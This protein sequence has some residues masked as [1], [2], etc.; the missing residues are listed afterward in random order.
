MPKT[1]FLELPAV[2]KDKIL[3]NV[4]QAF[5]NKGLLGSS[6]DDIAQSINVS[7]EAFALYFEGL[8]DVIAT[9][10][11]RGIQY[12]S[13]AY[14]E[15]GRKQ[16][17]FW[18][19]VE[20]L[21]TLAAKRGIAFSPF[22]LVY[23]NVAAQNTPELAQATFDR[24]EGR[25]ALFFQNLILAGLQEGALRAELDV[26]SVAYH[27]QM[28]TRLIMT[29]RSHPSFR[30]HSK[31]YYPDIPLDDEGD[32]RLVVRMISHLKSAYGAE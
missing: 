5:N 29:R 31:A 12:F 20:L 2:T 17:P 1:A 32:K 27:F 7:P 24:F 25:A 9:V 22:M 11:G 8:P 30:A 16:G 21:F 18:E 4:A 10:L 15:V 23:L 19:K 6:F 3:Y 13:E 26:V 14:I 28:M